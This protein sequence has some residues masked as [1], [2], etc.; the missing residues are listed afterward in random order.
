MKIASK[1]TVVAHATLT[2]FTAILATIA[3][4]QFIQNIP[5]RYIILG[6]ILTLFVIT[7]ISY[8]MAEDPDAIAKAKITNAAKRLSEHGWMQVGWGDK[9]QAVVDAIRT[10]NINIFANDATRALEVTSFLDKRCPGDL[11]DHCCEKNANDYGNTMRELLML[12][13]RHLRIRSSAR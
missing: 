8:L 3:D 13:D 5:T 7:L 10:A 9:A 12:I 6:S 2:A 11:P 4:V 1:R